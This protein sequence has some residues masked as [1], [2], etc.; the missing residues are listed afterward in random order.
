MK[1]L[2]RYLLNPITGIT[3]LLTGLVH[4]VQIT[5]LDAVAGVVWG[6][7]GTLFPAASITAFSLVP[8]LPIPQTPFIALT[9][10]V[11][12]LYVAKLLSGF[13]DAVQAKL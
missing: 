5:W 8:H 1:K 6:Q 12:M 2:E 13:V 7:L 11:G 4:V 10:V 3:A 9:L